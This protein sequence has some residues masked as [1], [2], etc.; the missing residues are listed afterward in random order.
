M[1]TPGAVT[2]KPGGVAKPSPRAATPDTRSARS[3][4]ASGTPESGGQGAPNGARVAG[5]E[6]NPQQQSVL[7]RVNYYRSMAGL[8]P[9]AVSPRL[10]KVAQSHTAYLDSSDEMG[11]YETNRSNP[12]YTGHGPF[13]RMGAVGYHYREAGE[14]VA[15]EPSSHPPAAIDSLITAIYHRF[16]ILLN[17]VTHAGPGVTLKAHKGVDELNVTVDFG[18][19]TTP[20]V[21]SPTELTLYPIDGQ[22]NV[23]T[24]FNPTT[25][26]PSPL[27]DHPLTGFPVSLQVDPRRVLS[28]G[29]FAL[30]E[31]ALGSA[32]PALDAKLLTHAADP[33]TPTHAAAL[34]PISPF[35]PGT[36]Y[37][38]SFSGAVDGVAVSRT[39][40]FTTAPAV[41]VT[42]LFAA[43]AVAPGAIQ[44]IVLRDVDPAKGPYYVCYSPARLISSVVHETELD[45]IMTTST[46]CRA[47]EAC[48]V[49][50]TATY[51]SACSDPFARGVFAIGP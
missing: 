14:V 18:A 16:I 20:P 4:G 32:A 25:E 48:S 27:P 24:D 5:V 3:P 7:E 50:V 38:V 41:P 47:G 42:M 8:A 9:V 35:R 45:I 49:T 15:R 1:R 13:D 23:P 51:H 2:G 26:E 37:R 19:E 11:H 22:R 39:W 40:Q 6:L 17:N 21:P 30:Y 10:L 44:R 31:A 46:D 12:D 43:P 36:A 33:E 28:V 29:A 34:I